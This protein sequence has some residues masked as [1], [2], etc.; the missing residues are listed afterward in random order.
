[1]KLA[2][3]FGSFNPLTNAHVA[4]METAVKSLG[5]DK[6]LFVATNGQY[7]RRK[8]VKIGNPFYLSEDERR[9]IIEKVCKQHDKLEFWGFEMGGINPKRYQTL[10]KIQKQYP[11]AVIYEVQGAD[12]V[13]SI[14]KLSKSGEYL[15]NIRFAVFERDDI[16]LQNLIDTTPQLKSHQDSFVILPPL[17]ANAQISST[18]V[19][20]RFEMGEDY[21]DIVP[22]AAVEVLSRYKPS[23]FSIS[24]AERMKTIIGSGRFGINRACQEV[25]A[26]NNVIFK[27][28]KNGNANVDFGDYYEFL[29]NTKLYKT[30]YSVSDLGA[31][32]SDTPTGCA[33]VDCVDMAKR[34][35]DLGYNPAILNL[36]SAG[37]PGGGYDRGM[38]AQ[39]ESLCQCSNLSLSLYQYADPVKHRYVRKSDV[40]LKC[41]GYPLD[42]NFGGLYTPNVTFFRNNSSN[43]FTFKNQPFKCDVITVAALSFNGRNDFARA[44]EQLYRSDDGGFT[45]AG[46][47][48]MLNKI[49][50]IF[51]MGVEHGKDALVLGAFGNGAYKLPVYDVAQL[52]RRV[53]NEPEFKNKF[54]LITFAILERTRKPNGIDGKF[55]PYYQEFGTYMLG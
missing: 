12:K 45:P 26:E 42:T 16:D 3:L 8:A 51:R 33:N 32:Y 9:D 25:F 6:G 17:G 31:T 43:Y 4:A 30:E 24:Y 7:L 34:L 36:A 52:F 19:R 47:A 44:C 14:T 11:D 22:L 15:D 49:R 55:A 13:H 5:A 2:V 35:I 1:M 21:T 27:D 38:H 10:C 40:P 29:D 18:E 53:M 46:E 37:R 41:A 54:R 48:I 20:R 50:T 23:D 28:W 39:E